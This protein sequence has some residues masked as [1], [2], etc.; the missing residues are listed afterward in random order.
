[1]GVGDYRLRIEFWAILGCVALGGLL[2][3]LVR[4][5]RLKEKY[6]LLWF[7]TSAVLLT[8]TLKRDWLEVFAQFVGIYYA[9]SA[10]FLLLVFFMLLILV[11]FS[12]VISQLL[13]DKQRVVQE[14]ALLEARVR[15]LES[16]AQQAPVARLE[17]QGERK[18]PAS[19]VR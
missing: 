17:D 10:L 19:G 13:Q 5:N 1:M 7:L 15:E 18:E 14:L 8:L 16:A 4:R 2:I 3:E 12:T 9:P 6:S 11:H